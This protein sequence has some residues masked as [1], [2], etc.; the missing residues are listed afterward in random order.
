MV[1]NTGIDWYKVYIHYRLLNVAYY[2]ISIWQ[3]K[4]TL[5]W[6]L[7]GLIK[8]FLYCFVSF[9]FFCKDFSKLSSR[10]IRNLQEGSFVQ[11]PATFLIRPQRPMGHKIGPFGHSSVFSLENAKSA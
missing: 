11:Q 10:Y 3:N 5:A 4:M 1:N 2:M 8:A 6:T 7:H 9:V